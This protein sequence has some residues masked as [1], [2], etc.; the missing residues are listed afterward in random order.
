MIP[1]FRDQGGIS[2]TLEAIARDPF[3]YDVV[4]VDDG[5]PKPIQCPGQAGIH[6]VTLLRLDSNRGIEHALNAGL[7]RLLSR[8]YRYIARLDADDTPMEGRIAR[9]AEFLDR[10]ADVGAVGT[11]AKCVDDGGKH[12]FTL[13][14]PTGHKEI[15]R[16]QRYVP[17]MLHPTVMIRADAIREIG[18]YSDRYKTAEDYD[19]FVRLG[20][21]YRLAN[22][23]AVLTEYIV[24]NAGT[25]IAKRRRNLVSRLRI[26]RDYFSWADPHAYLGVARTILFMGIPFG[27][28]IA[29]KRRLWQ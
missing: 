28:L 4:V 8:E 2:K 24:S 1:V 17:A 25:T 21:K 3:P 11:W 13:R 23:P 26:Q 27:L 5:S 14:F 15:L 12:L 18:L 19:L 29:V 7:Q 22:I 16:K 6:Q 20:H 10:N 9:Q